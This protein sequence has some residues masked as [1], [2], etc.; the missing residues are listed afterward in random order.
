MQQVEAVDS[1]DD[2]DDGGGGGGGVHQ[3]ML[4][5]KIPVL[6]KRKEVVWTDDTSVE[7]VIESL[8]PWLAAK[9]PEAADDDFALYFNGAP[10]RRSRLLVECGVRDN[11]EVLMK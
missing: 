2:D 9:L 3:K 1:D 11:D 7:L 6:R 5:V 4:R 8:R 10:L